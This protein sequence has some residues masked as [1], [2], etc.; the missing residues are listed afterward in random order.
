MA[1]FNLSEVRGKRMFTTDGMA[2]GTVVRFEIDPTLWRVR[3]LVVKVNDTAMQL[4]ELKKS[5][6]TANEILVGHDIV[7]SVGDVVN[8]GVSLEMLKGQLAAPT[9]KK[10]V[11]S[12]K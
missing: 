9:S 8:L 3:S 7:K 1:E 11:I 6:L 10:Q 5:L 4:L 2:V 12:K